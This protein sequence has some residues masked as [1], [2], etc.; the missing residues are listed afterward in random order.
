VED[1]FLLATYLRSL[2]EQALIARGPV[3]RTGKDETFKNGFTIR[4]E[5][6]PNR[7]G[8]EK[9]VEHFA[10]KINTIED[11]AAAAEAGEVDGLW[12]AAGYRDDWIDRTLAERLRQVK[13]LVVGDLFHS[14]LWE[15]ADY[16]LPAV[17]FAEREGS[18][19]NIDDRLQSF[20]WAIRPPAGA[21]SEGRI[22]WRLLA[23]PGL[24]NG[25]VALSDVAAEIPFFSA[26]GGE[27][28]PVGVDLKSNLL[29]EASVS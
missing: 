20:T 16:Q 5:K 4:A 14:P 25:R 26:A 23:R 17:A 22:A 13:L 24:Y 18:Y 27:V 15:L 19:V 29:A 7:R 2:D 28:P 9:V 8:V 12:V 3:P 11:V 10:G 6:C 21:S 1:A